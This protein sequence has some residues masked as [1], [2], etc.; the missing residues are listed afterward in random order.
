M[1]PT[2]PGRNWGNKRPSG[3][4]RMRCAR[5][6]RAVRRTL[7]TVRGLEELVQAAGQFAG[8]FTRGRTDH[9][10]WA[11]VREAGDRGD[12]REFAGSQG[13]NR[14]DARHASRPAGEETAAEADPQS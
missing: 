5:V 12:R 3:R 7:G 14:A 9:A 11:H 8:A 13:T 10:V 6:D 1:R 2:R 4:W